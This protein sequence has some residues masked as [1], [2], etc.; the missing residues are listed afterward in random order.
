MAKDHSHCAGALIVMHKSGCVGALQQVA[1][2]LGL[3]DPSLL[4]MDA[5]VFPSLKAWVEAHQGSPLRR[6][7]RRIWYD[8]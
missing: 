4:N 3:F 1:E 5:P 7:P 6:R 8:A 2:R